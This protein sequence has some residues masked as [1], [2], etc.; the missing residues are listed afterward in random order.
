METKKATLTVAF[1]RA[2]GHA[3]PVTFICS[4]VFRRRRILARYQS[5][6]ELQSIF[7]LMMVTEHHQQRGNGNSKDQGRK[8]NHLGSF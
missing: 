2:I 1:F 7:E 4:T 6:L 3:M 8:A 5:R